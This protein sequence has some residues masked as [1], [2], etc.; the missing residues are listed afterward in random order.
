MP[1]LYTV[2]REGYRTRDFRDDAIAGLTV[3]I[4]ALPLAMA[5]AIASGTTPDKG[6]VTAIVAGFIISALGG[7]RFQIGGPTGAFVVVVFNVIHAHG[8]DG[9]VLATLMAGVMLL[10]A[11]VVR[12]GD[13][14][15]YIPDPVVTGFTSGIAVIIFSSQIGDL[16]G[17]SLASVPADFIAKWTAFWQARGGFSPWAAGVA[18]GALGVIIVLRRLAPKQ[19]G[20]LIA[21][22]AASL[23]VYLLNIPVD[24]IGSRFGGIPSSLPMPNLP[25]ITFTR[26][27]ELLPSAFTI[28]FL[29]GVESLLSAMVADGMTGTAASLQLRTDGAG[30]GQYRLGA[31]RRHAR[32][33]RHCAH[34]HQYPLRCKI[35][36]CRD[37]ACAVCVAVYPAAGTAGV[38]HSDGLA[39]GHSGHCRLE[40]ERG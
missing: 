12:F 3:A 14:I 36:H 35:A 38:L 19:P 34:R 20:F 40:Y 10:I 18:F 9:L 11:G 23:L 15:K 25:E 29:A 33:R 24:T 4:V 27:Q 8:Y 7:S 39:G 17:L 30:D 22:I 5:L 31:V 13:W 26:L 1:K 28:A 16:F 32:N 2:L 21:V 6:L 37:A